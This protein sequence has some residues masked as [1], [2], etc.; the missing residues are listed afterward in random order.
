MGPN[1]AHY[2]LKPNTFVHYLK[3]RIDCIQEKICQL[4]VSQYYVSVK[5]CQHHD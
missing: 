1:G 4:Y 2:S 5:I 3:L